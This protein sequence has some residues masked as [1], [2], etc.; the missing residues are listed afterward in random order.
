MVDV[1]VGHRRMVSYRINGRMV[2]L[3]LW[4]HTCHCP[5][6]AKG[7]HSWISYFRYGAYN[8]GLRALTCSREACWTGQGCQAALQAVE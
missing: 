3:H 2:Y 8:V 7:S 4:H 6:D 1:C 5:T